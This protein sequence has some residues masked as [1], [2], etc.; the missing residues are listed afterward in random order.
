MLAYVNV[1]KKGVIA[2]V[3]SVVKF[4]RKSVNASDLKAK[5]SECNLLELTANNDKICA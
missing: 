1:I 4:V 5:N 3:S 2:E